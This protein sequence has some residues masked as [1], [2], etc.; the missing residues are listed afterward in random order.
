MAKGDYSDLIWLF[1][2]R[3]MSGLHLRHTPGYVDLAVSG[4]LPLISG[5][6][7]SDFTIPLMSIGILEYR[8]SG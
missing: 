4:C 2:D 3:Q 6:D 1:G 7:G 8:N 5:D